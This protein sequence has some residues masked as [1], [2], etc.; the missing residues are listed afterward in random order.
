MVAQPGD[1]SAWLGQA[2]HESSFY[3]GA[4]GPKDD[5]DRLSSTHRGKGRERTPSYDDI[6]LE[7]NEFSREVG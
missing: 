7:A 6:D 5:R 4:G 3:W 2:R 1:V